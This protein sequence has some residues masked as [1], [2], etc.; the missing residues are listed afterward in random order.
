MCDVC[1]REREREREGGREKEKRERIL[2]FFN[3]IFH[4]S[5]LWFY[6]RHTHTHTRTH[7]HTHTHTTSIARSQLLLQQRSERDDV[8]AQD[9]HHRSQ[10]RLA[11]LQ[12]QAPALA[13]PGRHLSDNEV[14]QCFIH[15]ILCMIYYA[16]LHY[17]LLNYTLYNHQS[18]QST[19]DS[20]LRV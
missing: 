6:S 8:Q 12:E 10:G 17:A 16:L 4:F 19:E 11:R 15:Y 9:S 1:V 13:T 3:F 2:S 5:L 7:A 18:L 14:G 20:R